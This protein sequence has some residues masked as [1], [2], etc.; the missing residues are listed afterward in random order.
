MNLTEAF[1]AIEG[2][3]RIAHSTWRK[4]TWV[5]LREDASK[6]RRS[7]DY[8]YI[9]EHGATYSKDSFNR[10]PVFLSGW[11]L[12]ETPEEKKLRC[13]REEAQKWKALA[14]G[15]TKMADAH[16]TASREEVAKVRAEFQAKCDREKTGLVAMLMANPGKV[17][18]NPSQGVFYIH[19][20]SQCASPRLVH[21]DGRDVG[22]WAPSLEILSSLGWYVVAEKWV[23]CGASS[24]R[25]NLA[26]GCV[27][28]SIT[29]EPGVWIQ[30]VGD[31]IVS[32]PGSESAVRGLATDLAVSSSVGGWFSK[33]AGA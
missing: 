6:S 27:V 32:S 10:N 15:A 21:K 22:T 11:S 12:V 8:N 3:S 33:K 2:G 26:A 17:I 7:C 25:D 5:E 9:D 13:L 29:W 14:D 30:R 23:E 20:G 4:G 19:S 18:G 1:E 31:D 16:L 24:A 28:R